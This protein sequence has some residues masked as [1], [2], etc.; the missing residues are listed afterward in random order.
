[1]PRKS[2]YRKITEQIEKLQAE[3]NELE[4]QLHFNGAHHNFKYVDKDGHIR[5]MLDAECIDALIEAAAGYQTALEAMIIYN[6]NK[7][8][9]DVLTFLTSFIKFPHIDFL[10]GLK[11]DIPMWDER[12]KP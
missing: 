4:K 3:R 1:M 2:N 5:Y 11:N 12:K 10:H 7:E 9:R 6:Y 8:T